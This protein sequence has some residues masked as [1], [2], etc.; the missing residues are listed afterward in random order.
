[1]ACE[2]TGVND[3]LAVGYNLVI[4]LRLQTAYWEVMLFRLKDEVQLV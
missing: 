2:T 3:R 4:Q 1:M